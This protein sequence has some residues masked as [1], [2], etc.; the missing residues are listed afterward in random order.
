MDDYS[1]RMQ[2][3]IRKA[4]RADRIHSYICLG[5]ILVILGLAVYGA[6]KLLMG[7]Y[8]HKRSQEKSK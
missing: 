5:S 6:Y 1:K 3:R 7:D 8:G 4:D 2:E